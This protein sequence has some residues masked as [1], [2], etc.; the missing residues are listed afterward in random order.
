[1]SMI[2]PRRT[3]PPFAAKIARE[4]PVEMAPDPD[5]TR[6]YWAGAARFL[7]LEMVIQLRDAE[8]ARLAALRQALRPAPVEPAPAPAPADSAPEPSATFEPRVLLGF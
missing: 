7:P 1:M 5:W 6:R 3:G 8:A 2:V 4:G